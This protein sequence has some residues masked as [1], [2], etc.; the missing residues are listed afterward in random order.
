MFGMWPAAAFTAL[1]LLATIST[2]STAASHEPAVMAK[3]LATLRATRV[4]VVVLRMFG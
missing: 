1:R 3:G 4:D 2:G